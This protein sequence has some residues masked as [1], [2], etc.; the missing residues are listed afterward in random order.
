MHKPGKFYR[1]LATI[2]QSK[3][4]YM[5]FTHHHLYGH[6]RDVATYEDPSTARK[7]ETVY[8]F[9]PRCIRDSWLG[10]YREEKQSGKKWWGN[11]AVLSILA[12]FAFIVVIYLTFGLQPLILQM[13]ITTLAIIYL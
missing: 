9:I 2:H 4:F 10:V 11:H 7:G 8:Q 13:I 1:V 12:S 3:R 5:H 6:H